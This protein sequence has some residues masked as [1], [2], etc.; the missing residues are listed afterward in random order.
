MVAHY[1]KA[2]LESVV[3]FLFINHNIM[4]KNVDSLASYLLYNYRSYSMMPTDIFSNLPKLIPGKDG[5]IGLYQ[6]SYH[7]KLTSEKHRPS[8]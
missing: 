1:Q 5:T 6:C 8:L 7:G 2:P 4:K 3:E